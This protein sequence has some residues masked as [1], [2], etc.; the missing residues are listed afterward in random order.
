MSQNVYFISFYFVVIIIIIIV[1]PLLSLAAM[2][3]TSGQLS[4]L[5]SHI[6]N[7]IAKLKQ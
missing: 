7:I 3:I 6:F 2:I 5:D 1:R 4:A